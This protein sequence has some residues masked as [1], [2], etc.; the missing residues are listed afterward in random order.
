MR[1]RLLGTGASGGTPGN[2]RSHRLE[3]SALLHDGI[4]VLIDVTRN[5]EEQVHWIDS[6]D[7]VL[8]THAHRD[9][10]GGIPRLDRWCNERGRESLPLY[11][12]AETIGTVRRRHVR[13]G[14]LAPTP[15]QPGRPFRLGPFSVQVVEVPHARDT[16]TLAWRL[17]TGRR[18]VVYASDVARLTPELEAAAAGAAVLVIDGAMWHRS[19]YTHLRI[20]QTVPELCGWPTDR[21]VLTQIGRS[22]PP[23]ARLER[24]VV[25]LCARASPGFDGMDI[26]I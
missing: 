2:G 19:L 26:D 20:D 1:L 4:S 14:H 5:F 8:L 9:A 3:S 7:A 16:P 22:A 10:S 12:H 23:H 21:I 17:S 18:T 15:I 13:L 6:I 24:E 11:A 25:L